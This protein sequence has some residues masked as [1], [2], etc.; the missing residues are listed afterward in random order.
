MRHLVWSAALTVALGAACGSGSKKPKDA[1]PPADAPSIDAQPLPACAS[2]VHGTTISAVMVGRVSGVATLATSPFNDPRL[3]VVEEQ[4]RVRVF[5]ANRQLLDTPFLDISNQQDFAAGGEQGLLG[6]AFHPQFPTNGYFYVWYTNGPCPGGPPAQAPCADV[7]ERFTVSSTDPNQA[8]PASGVV[9]LSI[10]DFATNHNAGMLEFGSDG[11][12]YISTGD[13]GAGGDPARNGQNPNALLAKILRID[14]DHPAAGKMYGIPADNPYAAGGGAPE[15]YLIGVR[16]PWRWTF[17]RGTGDM[18]IADVGQDCIEEL[19]VLRAGTAKGANLGWSAFEANQCCAT[20]GDKCGQ[21][22][23]ANQACDV[24]G[25]FFPQVTWSHGTANC[26]DSTDSG[27]RAVIG[28]QVYRGSCYPD[29]VGNYYFS[30]NTAGGLLQA[31][32][33]PDNSVTVTSLPAPAGGWPS[34]P[35]SIHADARG[36]LYETTTQGYVYQLVAGP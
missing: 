24:A 18:W 17:D 16:N 11:Y 12:L 32:F 21:G 3:F 1:G 27:F 29:I 14:V 22:G 9:I 19:N 35:A 34:S 7:L 13:G 23:G 20:E 36:E 25:K 28:G 26:P 6:L 8:D 31:N 30:D 2:P 10:P 33:Q 15:V 5:D 4:G